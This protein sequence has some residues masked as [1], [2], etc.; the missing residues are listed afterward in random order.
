MENSRA[1]IEEKRLKFEILRDT[2]NEVAQAYGLRFEF[3]DDLRALYKKFDIDLAKA[4]G[5][6]SWTLAMPARFIIDTSGVVRYARIDPDYTVRPE[7]IETL[8][9]LKRLVK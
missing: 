5:D 8:E 6:E 4:N 1:L 9:E 7:P 3:P 2:G